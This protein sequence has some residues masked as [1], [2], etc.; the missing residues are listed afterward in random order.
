MN[1]NLDK[2][3][4][5][6][7]ELLT[8]IDTLKSALFIERQNKEIID[9]SYNVTEHNAEVLVKFN[10]II[11]E[12]HTGRSKIPVSTAQYKSKVYESYLKNK[13]FNAD[14]GSKGDAETIQVWV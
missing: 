4:R 10:A 8:E 13:G 14:D 1:T 6:E 3:K 7:I 12:A 2:H 9:A 11:A 5:R